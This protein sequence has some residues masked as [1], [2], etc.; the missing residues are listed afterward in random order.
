[1]ST[2]AFCLCDKISEII[3]I[4][5]ERFI[6]APNFRDFSSWSLSPIAL[7]YSGTYPM[8]PM[9]YIKKKCS[10]WLESKKG[11][12]RP[13]IL[14]SLSRAFS[15]DLIL[16]EGLSLKGSATSSRTMSGDKFLTHGPLGGTF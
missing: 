11:N 13:W 7:G 4:N 14:V 2:W 6:L 10:W 5:K 9:K 16:P 12:G 8:N 15:N 1:M 3:Y